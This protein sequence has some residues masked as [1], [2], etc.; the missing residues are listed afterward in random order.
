MNEAFATWL[1]HLLRGGRIPPDS[2]PLLRDQLNAAHCLGGESLI[3]KL[4]LPFERR[5][6]D[7]RRRA[8]LRQMWI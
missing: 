5:F 1:A 7:Y 4:V 2:L 8:A 3:E 6:G